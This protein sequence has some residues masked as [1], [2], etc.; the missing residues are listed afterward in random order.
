MD[1]E[2][3]PVGASDQSEEG[4]LRR[5]R[6]PWCRGHVL[7]V[8]YRHVTEKELEQFDTGRLWETEVRV[9]MVDRKV[10][11]CQNGMPSRCRSERGPVRR[12]Q[13]VE[14]LRPLFD[15]FVCFIYFRHS[16]T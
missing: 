1:V 2:D 12:D 10:L 7:L 9:T 3:L 8:E 11:P 15:W 6:I 13:F 4:V 5:D 14:T 16:N